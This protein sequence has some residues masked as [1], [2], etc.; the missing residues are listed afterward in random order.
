MGM[1]TTVRTSVLAAGAAGCVLAPP[2]MLAGVDSPVR[3]VA[4]L[5]LLG[6]APGAAILPSSE[7]R[8]ALVEI[9][10]VVGLSIA[11]SALVAQTMLAL[12][13]WSPAAATWVVAAACIVPIGLR[14]RAIRHRRTRSGPLA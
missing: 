2:L 3:V 9:G 13:V 14:L 8:T 1:P 4:A 12:H 6:V 11:I 5:L 7:A 10:L